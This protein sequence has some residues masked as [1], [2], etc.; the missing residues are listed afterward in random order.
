MASEYEKAF[1]REE[2]DTIAEGDDIAQEGENTPYSTY[3]SPFMSGNNILEGKNVDSEDGSVFYEANSNSVIID[4]ANSPPQIIINEET[5]DGDSI[6]PRDENPSTVGDSAAQTADDNIKTITA[7]GIPHR[8][9]K[10]TTQFKGIINA[11]QNYSETENSSIFLPDIAYLPIKRKAQKDGEVGPDVD[12]PL[13]SKDTRFPVAGGTGPVPYATLSEGKDSS[14]LVPGYHATNNVAGVKSP[15]QETKTAMVEM[16]GPQNDISPVI[17]F[18]TPADVRMPYANTGNG[19][20]KELAANVAIPLTWKAPAMVPKDAMLPSEH[21]QPNTAP[22]VGTPMSTGGGPL[23]ALTKPV[24][25]HLAASDKSQTNHHGRDRMPITSETLEPGA[26]NSLPTDAATMGQP[27]TKMKAYLPSLPLAPALLPDDSSMSINKAIYTRHTAATARKQDARTSMVPDILIT[28]TNVPSADIRDRINTSSYQPDIIIEESS[29]MEYDEIPFVEEDTSGEGDVIYLE[30]ENTSNDDLMTIVL[31]NNVSAYVT[32]DNIIAP[33]SPIINT[34][35]LTYEPS[36]LGTYASYNKADNSYSSSEIATANPTQTNSTETRHTIIPEYEPSDSEIYTTMLKSVAPRTIAHT[37]SDGSKKMSSRFLKTTAKEQNNKVVEDAT[38]FLPTTSNPKKKRTDSSIALDPD[39]GFPIEESEP[40]TKNNFGSAGEPVPIKNK[41]VFDTKN[42]AADTFTLGRNPSITA[43]EEQYFKTVGSEIPTSQDSTSHSELPISPETNRISHVDENTEM[44]TDLVATANM[45]AAGTVA[46]AGVLPVQDSASPVPKAGVTMFLNNNPLLTHE[47]PNL[48]PDAKTDSAAASLQQKNKALLD[49]FFLGSEETEIVVEQMETSKDDTSVPEITLLSKDVNPP[50]SEDNVIQAEESLSYDTDLIGGDNSNSEDDY[51]ILE[52]NVSDLDVVMNSCLTNT[53]ELETIACTD[54]ITI[55]EKN[56]EDEFYAKNLPADKAKIPMET[57]TVTGVI[58]DGTET[59]PQEITAV[60]EGN[61]ATVKVTSSEPDITHSETIVNIHK[62]SDIASDW[63]PIF[64]TTDRSTFM[65]GSTGLAEDI[66]SLKN[67]ETSVPKDIR[68]STDNTIDSKAASMVTTTDATSEEKEEN[69][70][71][72]ITKL[73]NDVTPMSPFISHRTEGMEP[74]T[75][76]GIADVITAEEETP[77]PMFSASTI[78]TG[79][80]K[81]KDDL[82]A[83]GANSAPVSIGDTNLLK[84]ASMVNSQETIPSKEMSLDDA[85]M[86]VSEVTG[87]VSEKPLLVNGAP[88]LEW[89]VINGQSDPQALQLESTLPPLPRT[90]AYIDADTVGTVKEDPVTETATS[91]EKYPSHKRAISAAATINLREDTDFMSKTAR[92]EADISLEITSDEHEVEFHREKENT[93]AKDGVTQEE[94][95]LYTTDFSTYISSSN[96]LKGN[97][98][99]PQNYSILPKREDVDSNSEVNKITADLSK[100]A[101]QPDSPQNSIPIVTS[102]SAPGA[103]RISFR[104]K[105]SE[106]LSHSDLTGD[107]SFTA[108]ANPTMTKVRIPTSLPN[109]SG[110]NFLVSRCGTAKCSEHT[111]PSMDIISIPEGEFTSKKVQD[112]LLAKDGS[113]DDLKVTK[114]HL[115]NVVTDHSAPDILEGSITKTPTHLHAFPLDAARENTVSSV[116]S[117]STEYDPSTT[118]EDT[119]S[120]MSFGAIRTSPGSSPLE[121]VFPVTSAAEPVAEDPPPKIYSP[122][123]TTDITGN[124]AEE[125]LFFMDDDTSPKVQTAITPEGGHLTSL[126]DSMP[127]QSDIIATAVNFMSTFSDFIS[128]VADK[129]TL[130]KQIPTSEFN[131]EFHHTETPTTS[132]VADVSALT[133]TAPLSADAR[134]LTEEEVISYETGSTSPI[135]SEDATDPANEISVFMMQDPE[136]GK[137]TEFDRT[138]PSEEDDPNATATVNGFTQKDDI[139]EEKDTLG[140]AHLTNLEEEDTTT[141]ETSNSID[142]DSVDDNWLWMEGNPDDELNATALL[143]Y[144]AKIKD[145][146]DL[147]VSGAENTANTFLTKLAAGPTESVSA[148]AAGGPAELG[149]DS[150]A[151]TAISN[152]KGEGFKDTL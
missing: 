80:N 23:A 15:E 117:T 29:S 150:T 33:P 45:P 75:N 51:I 64:T 146:S 30:E 136:R 135:A 89:P 133:N 101:A 91:G 147:F 9:V 152:L 59:T 52:P 46:S 114:S 131:S 24:H 92:Y 27:L 105:D 115:L 148:A 2:E 111:P 97:E 118:R 63:D 85:D 17:S 61:R 138:V 7:D 134:P 83:S 28:S 142:V 77:T 50:V 102:F 22:E 124:L 14:T 41:E 72:E 62:G 38:T 128:S 31:D 3:S 49:D 127:E 56:G 71:A 68:F 35:T 8:M 70:V 26:D 10:M 120:E 99:D 88:N 87:P 18:T 25:G 1:L 4:A 65:T 84:D 129:I 98:L 58:T 42:V 104:N 113:L 44:V 103:D 47:N 12:S 110:D 108:E 94:N 95:T 126:D 79:Y 39:S 78:Y 69:E 54:S 20:R 19:Y 143:L 86:T 109:R 107:M 32:E 96:I 16:V 149:G 151:K 140:M 144:A 145:H 116:D 123:L 82:I 100:F 21:I 74:V 5:K 66:T 43:L 55:T 37:S 34:P 57:I 36:E 130:S 139:T 121:E 73:E 141:S 125:T 122:T 81:P 6:S 67:Q 106:T 11:G 60:E 76:S 53:N 132:D 40:F 93:I 48:T 137:I 13:A 90:P 112:T 119:T